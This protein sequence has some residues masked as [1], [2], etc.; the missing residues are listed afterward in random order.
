MNQENRSM[1][2]SDVI[3]LLAY[4]DVREATV[5]LCEA[6]GFAERLRIGSHR[7]QLTHGT[8]A[9]VVVEASADTTLPAPATWIGHSVM[10][11]VSNVDEHFERARLFGAQIISTP[12]DYPYGERQYT[13][14][15]L[16]GHRWTF[17][18]TLADVDPKSWGGLLIEPT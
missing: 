2:T 17:S 5:W 13:V 14:E 16:G 1:P 6:F 7:A 18:Q 9:F 10:A 8:G 4:P 15:D 12:A 3:P 11:R